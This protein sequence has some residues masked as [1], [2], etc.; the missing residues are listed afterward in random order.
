MGLSGHLVALFQIPFPKFASGASHGGPVCSRAEIQHNK[1][2]TT[3]AAAL[4]T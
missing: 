1:I 3:S 4:K 2:E